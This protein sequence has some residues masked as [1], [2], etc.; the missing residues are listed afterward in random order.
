MK[1]TKELGS[2]F[3]FREVEA[4]QTCRGGFL[5]LGILMVILGGI[6]IWASVATTLFSVLFAGI[7]LLVAGIVQVVHSFLAREWKGLFLSLFVGI[8]YFIT[9]LLCLTNPTLTAMTFTLLVGAY[10]LA[11][12]LFRILATLF[13]RFHYWGWVF[14]NGLVTAILGVLIV[15]QWP[16]SGLWVIGVFVGVDILLAGWSLI[17][18]SISARE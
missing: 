9:G 11:I 5:T 18:L 1:E 8:V 14:F 10:C 2:V 4:A 13:Y 17:M 15:T 6:G 7:L 16:V 12:G 3:H